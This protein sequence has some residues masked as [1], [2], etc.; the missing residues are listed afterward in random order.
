MITT[1]DLWILSSGYDTLAFVVNFINQDR[2]PCNITIGLFETPDT[3]NV[4]VVEEVKVLLVEF[5]LT[6]KVTTYVKDKTTNLNFFTTTFTFVMSYES[7]QLYQPLVTSCFGDVMS[8][9]CQY[10]TS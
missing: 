9:T 8:K 5:N 7:L 4:I 3:S 10:A 6:N 1:F 2:F